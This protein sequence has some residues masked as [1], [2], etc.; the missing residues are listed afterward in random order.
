MNE[1]GE[2]VDKNEILRITSSLVETRQWCVSINFGR[3]ITAKTAT[4]RKKASKSSI[5]AGDVEEKRWH[6]TKHGWHMTTKVWITLCP[7][8]EAG[9]WFCHCSCFV[10]V[11]MEE[12]DANAKL[13]YIVATNSWS[14]GQNQILS[15]ILDLS[16]WNLI[17][18]LLFG[19][20]E[21]KTHLKWT[22]QNNLLMLPLKGSFPNNGWGLA[23]AFLQYSEESPCRNQYSF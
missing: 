23:K 7:L 13:V 19:C 9:G 16:S 22:T 11:K 4:E 5:G 6:V 21:P 3:V 14:R 20:K 18:S 1:R 2:C 17:D 10:F 12:Q 8:A 15:L